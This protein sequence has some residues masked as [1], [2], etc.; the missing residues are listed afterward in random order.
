MPS[1]SGSSSPNIAK[2]DN[3]LYYTGFG[4]DSGGWPKRVA[5]REASMYRLGDLRD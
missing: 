4:V 5:V 1:F 2:W 3:R